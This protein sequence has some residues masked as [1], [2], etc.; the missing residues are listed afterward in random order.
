[1]PVLKPDS[2]ISRIFFRLGFIESEGTSED[3]LLETVYQG[4][5]F[6]DLTNHPIRYIDIIFVAY[7][8]MK[9]ASTS[10]EQ[11]IC[12]KEHP[13]CDMCGVTEYCRY[14]KSNKVVIDGTK[15]MN[16]IHVDG[17][18]GQTHLAYPPEWKGGTVELEVI[19]MTPV[20][21]SGN[22]FTPKTKE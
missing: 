17:T 2:V 16:I 10:T 3:Q 4:Q 15:V 14:F 1:M 11:G 12:L 8:A 18:V 7:G 21:E 13:R 5:K 9:S 19:E 6:R 20:D 22:P